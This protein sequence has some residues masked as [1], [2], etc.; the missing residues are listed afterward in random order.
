MHNRQNVTFIAKLICAFAI[1]TAIL[2]LLAP[3]ATSALAGT[4]DDIRAR[5]KLICGVSEGL[6]GFSEKEKSGTWSGFD[7]DFC[8]AVAGAVLGDIAKVE[9]VP[10][11][12]EDRFNALKN[13]RIDLL[14]RNTTWTMSREL[15]LG[16]EFAGISYFDGQGFLVPAIY[17]AT[18]PLQLGGASI[19]VVSGTTSEI[20]AASYFDKHGL[21]VSFL[22][23]SERLA[24]RTAYAAGKCDA[25]TG[26]RSALAAE[27]SL[28]SVPQDHV[29]LRDVISKEP[30]GPVTRQDDTQW[31]GL[32][33]WTLFALINAEEQGL[34]SKSVSTTLHQIALELGKPAASAMGLS[35]DWL[36]KV[37]GGVGNYAEIFER[38]LGTDTPLALGRGMNAL[39]TQGG[40][41]YAPPMH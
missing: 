39:W 33:R 28:L 26:D 4:L 13:R 27:R 31:T 10:L 41:L 14:S 19:C 40:L 5:N 3:F 2:T 36:V 24:A 16:V 38:N 25:F 35:N 6:P 9:F 21:H 37:I 7:V 11:S 18:S 20:N 32:V 17:G 22:R 23:F 15:E 30:L 1:T 34:S 12:A 29:I 8:K